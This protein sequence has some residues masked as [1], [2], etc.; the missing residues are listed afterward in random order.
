M[1]EHR[2]LLE[3]AELVAGDEVGI[4]DEVRRADRL[5]PEAQVRHRHRTR[6]LRVVDEVALG[7]QVGVL[8]DDLHRRLVR[9]DRAVGAEPEEHRLHLTGRPRVAEG[10][11]DVEAQ[12]GDVVVDADGEPPLRWPRRPG[13][14]EPGQLVEDRLDVGGAELL[15]RQAVAPADHVGNSLERGGVGVHRLVEGGDHVEQQRLARRPRLLGAVEHGDRPHGGRQGADEVLG[16]E[17][18][19]EAHLHQPDPLAGGRRAPRRSPRPHPIPSPSA[20][21]LDRHRGR[22]RSRPARSWR[23]QRAASSPNTSST[24]PGTRVIER[25]GRLAGL[26]EHIG[27]LRRAAQL[28]RVGREAALPVGEHGV[29][30]HQRPQIG[31]VEEVD[32]VHLVRRAE[33]VEE[34]Q[35]RHAGAQRGGVSDGREVVGLLHAAGGEHR[36]PGGA[37]VHD[38]GMVAEDRQ[39]VRGDRAG[40]D[41]HRARRQLAGDLEHVRH[42][43]QQALRRR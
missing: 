8:A 38:V 41:V 35:E 26:E 24:M 10:V 20:R 19:V 28:R 42:H 17:R 34:M 31:V 5:R 33:A 22:R 6:L 39:G 21:R 30:V 16:R 23:P 29:V 2:H 13:V 14:V 15:R 36:P 3:Q 27:V 25:V 1:V 43:Q 11:V 40:G 18:S 32:L 12:P 9:P 7:E 4:L 37:R